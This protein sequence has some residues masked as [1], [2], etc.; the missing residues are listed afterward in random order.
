[1]KLRKREQMTFIQYDLNK[2]VSKNNELR[3][4][5]ELISFSEILKHFDVEES[6]TGREGYGLE[7]GLKCLFMQF[8]YDLSDREMEERLRNDMSFRL[9][10]E[11]T[12]EDETPDHSYFCRVRK[13]IGTKNIGLFFEAINQ[14]AKDKK[15]MRGIFHFVDSSAIKAKESTWSERDKAK[16]SG[17]DKVNNSNIGKFS[18]DKDARFGNKG[19]NKYWFGYKRH[20]CVDVASGLVEKVAVTPAN[21]SDAKS[22]KYIC[23]KEG[24][25]FCDKA[26]SI[27]TAQDIL[28]ANLCHSGAIMK[29]NRK[30]KDR[31]KDKWLTK[32]RSPFENTFSKLSKKSRYRGIA[33]NQMQ[34]FLEAIVFNVKRL[35][36]IQSSNYFKNLF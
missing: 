21:Q 13:L 19:K 3:K 7:V 20:Q 14:K 32:I 6:A 18:A 24:M 31:R 4:V 8:Y 22:L 36:V 26:Y 23:P 27:K 25:V 16:L 5:K 33:K 30:D 15:V 29:N 17:E 9:F 2:I 35:L 12:I 1:M 34:V 11:F 10:C 28:K